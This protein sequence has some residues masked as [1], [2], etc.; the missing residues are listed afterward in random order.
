MARVLVLL[1]CIFGATTSN[2]MEFTLVPLPNSSKRAVIGHGPITKGD[3]D[4]LRAALSEADRDLNGTKILY[5]NSLGGSV[6]AALQMVRVMDAVGVSTVLSND[7]VCASAC[8]SIL[9]VSGKYNFMVGNAALGMH[10]CYI[11]ST[12]K[13]D[14]ICNEEVAQNAIAH[15]IAHGSVMAFTSLVGPDDVIWFNADRADCF[16][17]TKWPRELY[18]AS[19]SKPLNYLGSCVRDAIEKRPKR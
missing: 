18:R 3:A 4:G 15:G 12:R 6:D 8:A 7:M 16:G 13:A 2:G 17:L 9:F 14:D 1:L 10:T 5:L 19:N 11:R